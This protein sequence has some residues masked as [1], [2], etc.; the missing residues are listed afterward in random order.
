M[1]CLYVR[2]WRVYVRDYRGTAPFKSLNR[3]ER[4]VSQRGADNHYQFRLKRHSTDEDA[5]TYTDPKR[6]SHNRTSYFCAGE[7]ACATY[8]SFL[9]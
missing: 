4:Q 6:P 3:R 1:P 7:G 2:D 9:S 8:F 5:R